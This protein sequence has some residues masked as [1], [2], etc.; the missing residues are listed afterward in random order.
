MAVHLV[1]IRRSNS[2]AAFWAQHE[3][4]RNRRL[5]VEKIHRRTGEKPVYPYAHPSE[6]R[7]SLQSGSSE[8]SLS[9]CHLI[10]WSGEIQL[11]SPPQD[12]QVHFDTGTADFWIPSKDC[13]STCNAFPDWRKYDS[14]RSATYEIASDNPALNKFKLF[15]EDGEWVREVFCCTPEIFGFLILLHLNFRDRSKGN[16]QWTRSC[17]V[18]FP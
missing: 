10:L 2:N 3:H 1:P 11:G 7:R 4:H 14:A 18:E 9:N 13:D 5:E 12:F 15:Y 17:L 8:I 16:M 6:W